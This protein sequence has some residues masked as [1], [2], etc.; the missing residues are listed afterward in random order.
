MRRY[1]DERYGNDSRKLLDHIE[2][3]AMGEMTVKVSRTLKNIRKRQGKDAVYDPELNPSETDVT[4]TPSIREMLDATTVLLAYHQGKP[5]Q[6]HEHTVEVT[7]TRQLDFSRLSVE[8]LA[9]YHQALEK[10]DD[11]IEDAEFK[12][13][14]AETKTA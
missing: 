1:M 14:P 10:L 6:G 2:K 12:A 3:I 4:L 7:E 5:T 9:A 13:L 8:E 11:D